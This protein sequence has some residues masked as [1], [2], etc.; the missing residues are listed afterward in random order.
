MNKQKQIWEDLAKKNSM[1][2]INSDYG[3]GITKEQFVNSGEADYKRLVLN[4][5]MIDSR[6]SIL[7]I[8]CGTGRMTE[9]MAKDFEQVYGVDISETMI[10]EGRERLIGLSN[11]RLY[12]TDGNTFPL[13]DNSIDI[14]FSY[15]VFQHIKTKEM[16]ESNFRDV[17]RVLK[18]GGLFKVLLRADQPENMDK[19]WNG[20]SYNEEE[21]DTL[22]KTIGF[23][24]LKLE[25]VKT[26]AI[27]VWMEK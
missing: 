22:C 20:V 13:P 4:D 9:F 16:V 12:E 3:K 11:V 23:T 1:Y 24:L 27:W 14:A 25:Y 26:Y 10:K 6:K 17:Y 2:Y 18:K 15:I 8:G 21:I 19:W 7:D 5:M